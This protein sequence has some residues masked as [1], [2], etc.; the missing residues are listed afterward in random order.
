MDMM[1]HQ[2]FSYLKNQRSPVGLKRLERMLKLPA[3]ER[4]YLKALLKDMVQEGQLVRTRDAL[5]A[6]TTSKGHGPCVPALPYRSIRDAVVGRTAAGRSYR[7]SRSGKTWQLS[8]AEG[9]LGQVGT[10]DRVLL[11]DRGSH[12]GK[13]LGI[14][15]RV[16]YGAGAASGDRSSSPDTVDWNKMLHDAFTLFLPWETELDFKP[17]PAELNGR[18]D[19][20]HLPVYPLWDAKMQSPL[21]LSCAQHPDGTTLGFHLLDITAGIELGSRLDEAA[22]FRGTS[23]RLTGSVST[24]LPAFSVTDRLPAI[25]LFLDRGRGGSLSPWRVELNMVQPQTLSSA[26]LDK[27]G[28]PEDIAELAPMKH[29]LKPASRSA[30]DWFTAATSFVDTTLTRVMLERGINGVQWRTE[31]DTPEYLAFHKG[32]RYRQAPV[33][34]TDPVNRYADLVNHRMLKAW[35]RRE[36]APCSMGQ[37]DMLAAACSWREAVTAKAES[38]QRLMNWIGRFISEKQEQVVVTVTGKTQQGFCCSLQHTM[39]PCIVPTQRFS[40]RSPSIGSNREIPVSWIQPVLS[41]PKLPSLDL[42]L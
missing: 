32:N 20:C 19:I 23:A 11:L 42:R 4:A 18:V 24:L 6:V 21:M 37:L 31:A 41:P 12:R 3:G 2:I 8:W 15:D 39:E 28:S 13:I 7:E 25:S 30:W 22:L 36:P 16:R 9:M 34:F 26:G 27:P 10:G 33:R 38:G 14:V 5:Y 29:V 17:D 1:K 40:G 35:L